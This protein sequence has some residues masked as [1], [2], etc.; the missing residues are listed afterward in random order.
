MGPTLVIA[1]RAYVSL[2]KQLDASGQKFHV[3]KFFRNMVPEVVAD[4]ARGWRPQSGT[5]QRTS[6]TWSHGFVVDELLCYMWFKKYLG[7]Y[8]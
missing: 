6:P 5:Q 7:D 1:A 3:I 2:Q 8:S 4:V